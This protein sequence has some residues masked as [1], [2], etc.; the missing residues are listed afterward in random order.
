MSEILGNKIIAM[1]SRVPK[2]MMG[3]T[4]WGKDPRTFHEFI[5]YSLNYVCRK[6][7]RS[8]LVVLDV[9]DTR[10]A[11][12]PKACSTSLS[13]NYNRDEKKREKE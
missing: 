7:E 8:S 12:A 4:A 11:R 2:E 9:D 13:L 3:A 5:E 1:R 6:S 10:R